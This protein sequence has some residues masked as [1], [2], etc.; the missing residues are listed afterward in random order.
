M[1]AIFLMATAVL[2]RLPVEG[3]YLLLDRGI[4]DAPAARASIGLGDGK[5]SGLLA[6]RFQ[7][8]RLG[9]NWVLDRLRV[10]GSFGTGTFEKA[11]LFGGLENS[12]PSPGPFDCD[13]HNLTA[14]Q[15]EARP[16]QVATA[17]WQLDF[18][19]LNWSVPGGVAIEFGVSAPG[20]S[21]ETV[22][23]GTPHQIRMVDA[24]GKRL[25][26]YGAESD[27]GFAVQVWGH[28]PANIEIRPDG[29]WWKV[30]LRDGA[31]VDRASL[32]FGPGSAR[33][34]SIQAE[35][36]GLAMRFR[37]GETGIH[38]GDLNACLS[39]KRVNGVPFE[40]CDLLKRPRPL[41]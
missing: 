33:P 27:A 1:R 5:N 34:V 40:G 37:A 39:G 25:G 35:G 15:H 22:H 38:S 10:W 2:M 28:L 21:M 30:K 23:T 16:V 7:V 11:T 3:Q 12:D 4:K 24:N 41:K 18:D 9:E 19:H 31:K 6:D 20:W 13:C 17:V 8:G 26:A 32:R 36:T 29:E 14:I